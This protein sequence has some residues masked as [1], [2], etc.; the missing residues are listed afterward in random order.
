MANNFDGNVALITGGSRGIGK[1]VALRFAEEG[2]KVVF[3]DINEEALK[4]V[5]D[6]FSEK[7]FEIFTKV[8]NVVNSNP[9]WWNERRKNCE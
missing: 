6:D 3:I 2:A 4:E 9:H 1:G 5:Q 7:G 8:T